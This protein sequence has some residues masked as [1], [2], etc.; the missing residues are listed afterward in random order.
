MNWEWNNR[1]ISRWIGIALSAA[2]IISCDI[3]GQIS[4]AKS[5]NIPITANMTV[6]QKQHD[7]QP[8]GTVTAPLY[9]SIPSVKP[10]DSAKLRHVYNRIVRDEKEKNRQGASASVPETSSTSAVDDELTAAT[11]TTTAPVQTQ[12][13]ETTAPTQSDR[14]E[15]ESNVSNGKLPFNCDDVSSVAPGLNCLADF[16]N[17]TSPVS[18]SWD[19]SAYDSSGVVRITLSS[20]SGSVVL[21]VKPSESPAEIIE[22]YT[23][24]GEVSG[25]I[26]VS[27]LEE[28]DWYR[29]NRGSGANIRSVTWLRREFA[30]PPVRGVTVGAGLAELTASY[31]CVNGGATTLY[32]ASD[33]MEDEAKLNKLLVSE[34]AYTFV[35]GRLYTVESYLEKYYGGDGSAYAFEDCDMVVQYGCNSI[36]EHNDTTGA[37]LMEYAIQNDVVVG[38]SFLNKSYYRTNVVQGGATSPSKETEPAQGEASAKTD[39]NASETSGGA[40][41]TAADHPS[42]PDM[43]RKTAA[44]ESETEEIGDAAQTTTAE[45]MGSTGGSVEI[46]ATSAQEEAVSSVS[47]ADSDGET[48]E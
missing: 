8:V 20:S 28:L 33:V 34:N 5:T 36:M 22:P 48:A 19:T 30:I 47:S 3:A 18:F 15:T 23:I 35:G 37:W 29:S 26:N 39:D 41:T 17:K 40:A 10:E 21:D 46:E 2:V 14:E 42:D 24:A 25:S 16:V 11:T 7:I 9:D 27:A 13:A 31:L 12:S 1:R 43:T 6:S 38:I 45:S 4:K 44:V 32:K